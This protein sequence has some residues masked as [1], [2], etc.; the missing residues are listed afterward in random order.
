MKVCIGRFGNFS[1]SIIESLSRSENAPEIKNIDSNKIF[2]SFAIF[3]I[4]Y[5][6]VE[7]FKVKLNQ[8]ISI[9]IS[10]ESVHHNSNL[11]MKFW[12][13]SEIDHCS[14]FSQFYS[15]WIISYYLLV[16]AYMVAAYTGCYT[17]NN[18][19]TSTWYGN[20]NDI[21]IKTTNIIFLWDLWLY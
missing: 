19:H 12:L 9:F 8:T 20:R 17:Y 3:W 5:S 13:D 14:L 21:G 1:K 15:K 10:V 4:S 2:E 11:L 6:R 16:A 18:H 7:K